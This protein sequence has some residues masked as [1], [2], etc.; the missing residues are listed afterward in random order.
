MTR[1]LW[2]SG[3]ASGLMAV[4]LL[5]IVAGPAFGNLVID[6]RAVGGAK[7]I[8]VTQVGQVV[9]LEVYAVVT[10]KNALA[11]DSFQSAQGSFIDSITGS[12]SAIGNFSTFTRAGPFTANAQGGLVQQLGGGPGVDVGSFDETNTV[13]FNAFDLVFSRSAIPQT[14]QTTVDNA[15]AA[16]GAKTTVTA[17]PTSNIFLGTLNWTATSIPNAGTTT[18][19]WR[20]R[21]NNGATVATSALWGE[22]SGD[23]A[24]PSANFNP[25]T[26][27]AIASPLTIT[28]TVPEPA[29]ISLLGVVGVGLLARRRRIA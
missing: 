17:G 6:L 23:P 18:L 12:G 15:N 8:N 29:S 21:S 7:S 2:K 11:D 3:L 10:G 13:N 14:A 16:N 25:S 27:S 5:T 19:S 22:D 9:N 24:S 20:Y 1:K 26:G 4:G 28:T